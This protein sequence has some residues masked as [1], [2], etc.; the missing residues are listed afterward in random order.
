MLIPTKVLVSTRR[1][2]FSCHAAFARTF[3]AAL[4]LC[5]ATNEYGV[6]RSSAPVQYDDKTPEDEQNMLLQNQ[7]VLYNFL[8][9]VDRLATKT[10]LTDF[11]PLASVKKILSSIKYYE[12]QA[13]GGVVTTLS[14][15]RGNKVSIFVHH[16]FLMQHVHPNFGWG[17][18]STGGFHNSFQIRDSGQ[19]N[20]ICAV[21]NEHPGQAPSLVWLWR[22]M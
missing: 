12:D 22:E 6:Y 10:M 2:P 21:C 17:W 19:W 18:Y 16:L 11:T 14:G 1:T 13:K 8:L 15:K 7:Q 20:D 3:I 4:G 9:L 5:I